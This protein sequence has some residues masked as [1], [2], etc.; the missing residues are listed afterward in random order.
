ML[1][2]L[3]PLRGLLEE[4]M[5]GARR[6]TAWYAIGASEQY[7]DRRPSGGFEGRPRLGG[8]CGDPRPNVE[9]FM[10]PDA[11]H[12]HLGSFSD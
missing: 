1:D 6:C 8:T 5:K 3:E 12:V 2:I 7:V 9:I 4:R 10:F 11:S